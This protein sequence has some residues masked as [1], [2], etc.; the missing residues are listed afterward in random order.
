MS[1]SLG[2]FITCCLQGLAAEPGVHP[3]QSTVT[4]TVETPNGV[5]PDGAGFRAH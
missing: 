3:F 4:A 2:E 1:R 5:E